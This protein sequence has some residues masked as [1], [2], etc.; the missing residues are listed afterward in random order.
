[1]DKK[2]AKELAIKAVKYYKGRP[3]CKSFLY[4]NK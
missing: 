3:S 2:K 4:W 1:M